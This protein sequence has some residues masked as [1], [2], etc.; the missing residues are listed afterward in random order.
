MQFPTLIFIAVLSFEDIC[1][2][3]NLLNTGKS[4]KK[5][6]KIFLKRK[7]KEKQ[8]EKRKKK[9]RKK[10]R[11]KK[12]KEEEEVRGA[13][14]RTSNCYTRITDLCLIMQSG[15]IIL[16]ADICTLTFLWE[17]RCNASLGR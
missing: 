11:K 15:V 4:I 14:F 17:G 9:E 3:L 2:A 1:I 8:E 13:V 7:P 12:K 5:R 16:W 10:E 6:K